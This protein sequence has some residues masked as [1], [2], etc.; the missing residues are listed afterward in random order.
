[1][2]QNRTVWEQFRRSQRPVV[3]LEVGTL[4]RGNTWKMGVNGLGRGAYWGD[5]FD[6]S[7]VQLLGIKPRPWRSSGQ[8]IVIVQQRGDSEQWQGLPPTGQWLADTVAQLRNYT[9]RTIR[10][11]RHPRQTLQAP[12]GCV[13]DI[14]HRLP[15]AYDD[16]DL[17]TSLSTAWAVV[18][19]NSGAGVSAVLQGIP[20]FCYESSLASTVGNLDWCQIEQPHMPD[21]RDWLTLLAHTEWTTEEIASGYPI[22]RLLRGLESL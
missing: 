22:K 15:N 2:R 4:R 21:R 14:P 18:N 3:V 1:M 11:R 6:H 7:R 17:D 20:L 10:V 16:F 13:V 9:N 19:A 8:D 5:E 12:A